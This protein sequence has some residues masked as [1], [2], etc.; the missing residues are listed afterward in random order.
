MRPTPPRLNR[1]RRQSRALTSPLNLHRLRQRA[2]RGE[3]TAS[4]EQATPEASPP[5]PE[6][7][8][9]PGQPAPDA[10]PPSPQA[11]P[12]APAA[13]PV[14]R[15]AAFD[16]DVNLNVR[17]TRVAHLELGPSS[18]SLAFRDGILTATLGG[19]ELYD[20]HA[21]GKLVLDAAKPVPT[22]TSDIR[23]D[24]VQAKTLLSDA[25]Q[26]SML[27]GRTKLALQLSGTGS[28]AD[29]IKSSLQGQGSLAV[30]DGAIEGMDLTSMISALGEGQIPEL[31]QGPGAKTAFSDL[32]GSFTIASGIVETDN[33][34]MTEPASQGGYGGQGRPRAVEH[35]HARQPRDRGGGGREGRRQRP[36][37]PQRADQDRRP[38]RRAEDQARAERHVRQSRA[39][40]QD[41]QADRRGHQ[42]EVQGEAGR[43]GARQ[44]SRRRADRPAW[45]R[46]WQR[47]GDRRSR[48]AGQA[49][50]IQ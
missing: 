37:R 23:F 31:R 44:N 50:A 40:E 4:A 32:G 45:R 29:E 24:G 49:E 12:I 3:N 1:Q 35:R 46:Q 11:A 10:A 8:A 20:G 28:T 38:A 21:T 42:E 25:A 2:R 41:G 34:Q 17:Q 26:F 7:N 19:M 27:S 30:S 5:A 14:A 18:L 33:L 15:P 13:A 47:R 48:A 22:F 6:A 16:A 39:G 9:E 36:R 43:R